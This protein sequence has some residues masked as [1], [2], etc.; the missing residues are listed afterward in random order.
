LTDARDALHLT[1]L[2]RMDQIVEVRG[3]QH[4]AAAGAPEVFNLSVT[5]RF[6][7]A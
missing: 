6:T 2:L 1:R 7:A 5:T 3:A 4:R